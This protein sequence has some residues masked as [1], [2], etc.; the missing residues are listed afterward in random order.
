MS[1]DQWV[2]ARLED[3]DPWI[4]IVDQ[5]AVVLSEIGVE[6][7]R[8]DDDLHLS[9]GL[10]LSPRGLSVHVRDTGSV[11]TVT[12]VWVR[13]PIVF[14]APLFE[15][16]HGA[17]EDLASSLQ[18]GFIG[19]RDLDLPAL[20]DALRDEPKECTIMDMAFP[21]EEGRPARR[22]RIVLGPPGRYVLGP[23]A[24]DKAPSCGE[25]HSFC[26]C[27]LTTRSFDAFKPLMEADETFGVRLYAARTNDGAASANCRING[28]DYE[29]GA[30]ALRAYVGTWAQ[31]DPPLEY[32]KQYVVYQ[33][34]PGK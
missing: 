5:V 7:E 28:G 26:P 27:C 2:R 23:A 12:I 11:Q 4:D 32:R 33:T 20:R 25:E 8:R 16:Q 31:H 21:E 19:W 15:N 9:D 13:H 18:S 10:V 22:R 29:A 17:G 1:N 24:G 30:E 34:L 6:A 3:S 14:P